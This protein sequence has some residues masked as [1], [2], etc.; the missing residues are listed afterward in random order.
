MSE[1]AWQRKTPSELLV[2]QFYLEAGVKD[3]IWRSIQSN[4]SLNLDRVAQEQM[5]KYL[6][7]W[8]PPEP[9]STLRDYLYLSQ[10]K[11]LAVDAQLP[12]L[13]YSSTGDSQSCAG[14]S[15]IKELQERRPPES[16]HDTPKTPRDKGNRPFGRGDQWGAQSF[17]IIKR[18]SLGDTT[19]TTRSTEWASNGYRV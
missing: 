15:C 2:T 19:D 3:G 1:A 5:I 7:T 18:R 4:G 16:S 12:G 14:N 10:T 8:T 9:T 13:I 11:P 6:E 17:R